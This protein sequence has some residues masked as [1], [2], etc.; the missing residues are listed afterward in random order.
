MSDINWENIWK[1][2]IKDKMLFPTKN[3]DNKTIA[4]SCPTRFSNTGKFT[5]DITPTFNDESITLELLV[6][7]DNVTL[8]DLNKKDNENNKLQNNHDNDYNEFNILANKLIEYELSNRIMERFKIKSDGFSSE[9][10]AEQSLV[11]YINNKATES[12]RLFDDK[13]DELNDI[14]ISK[15]E[16]K[17]MSY[18]KILE[19][20]RVNR[21]FILKKIE[22]ILNSHYNWKSQKN[23]EFSDSVVSLYDKSNKLAAVVSLIDD[24]VLVDLADG[25]C[26]KVSVLQ[27]DAEIES[28]LVTDVDTAKELIDDKKELDL[29]KDAVAGN[30][31]SNHQDVYD[32]YVE[33]EED[34]YVKDLSKRISRLESLYIN[35]KLKRF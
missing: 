22:E 8:D 23:E 11:D 34:E 3:L 18:N 28:E 15:K 4:V 5:I 2:T 26:A 12:G 33:D 13:L 16:G 25:I 24:C 29:V 6:F 17:K 14:S 9:D 10:E 20:L 30:M 19:S 27:S 21:R 35:R 32:N 1:N 7:N 31:D